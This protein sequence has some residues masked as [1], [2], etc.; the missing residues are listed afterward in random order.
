MTD[1]NSLFEPQVYRARKSGL[2]EVVQRVATEL[3]IHRNN[4]INYEGFK[5]GVCSWYAF[6]R[7]GLTAAVEFGQLRRIG[8]FEA[9]RASAYVEADNKRVFHGVIIPSW[10]LGEH[11]ATAHYEPGEWEQQ[12]MAFYEQAQCLKARREA[13][14]DALR[15]RARIAVS[16]RMA[17]IFPC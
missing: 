4:S 6:E 5:P 7:E 3:G 2:F 16:P 14:K 8:Q 11:T 12:L 9:C 10:Y 15:Q 13:R 1:M 17:S